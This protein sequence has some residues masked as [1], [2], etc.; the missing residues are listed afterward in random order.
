M[1]HPELVLNRSAN[2]CR[3]FRKFR[4]HQ[5]I[6]KIELIDQELIGVESLN[7]VLLKYINRKVF[8]IERDNRLSR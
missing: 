3:L 2:S 7:I 5:G 6:V 1:K 4:S 8:E